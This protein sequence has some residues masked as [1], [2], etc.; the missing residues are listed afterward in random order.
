L[1]KEAAAY[2]ARDNAEIIS[3]LE[4][5]IIEASTVATF[6]CSEENSLGLVRTIDQAEVVVER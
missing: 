3:M 6:C 5:P 4:R 1:L 2:Y